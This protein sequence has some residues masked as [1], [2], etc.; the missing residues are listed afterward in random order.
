MR[1][2]NDRANPA[3]CPACHGQRPH[4]KLAKLND[5]TDKV[6]CQTCHIPKFAR[7]GIPTKMSWDWS[8]AGKRG[9]DGKPLLRKNDEGHVVYIGTKGDFRMG[10]NV[11]PD[12]VWFNGKVE[13][14]LV[15]DKIEKSSEP[16]HINRFRG[17]AGD[18]GSLIWPVK[19][20]RGRQAYDPDNKSLVIAHLAGDD[21]TAYWKNLDWPRAVRAGMSTAGLPFSGKV[22]FI[23]TVSVWPIT[24]MVA[25]AKNA[26]GCGECHAPD[27]RLEKISGI[28]IPGRATDHAQWLDRTGWTL[29]A[30]ALLGVLVH[31]A[32]RVVAARRRH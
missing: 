10:E 12:Y 21:D 27:G 22:E 5:H 26:L 15:G 2:K 13:Y 23:D 6:A 1:G 30:L 8:T 9:S 4:T 25:P 20:F 24:H 11:V 14:T 7:G 16:V 17:S 29:A 31:G 18:G 28:Y 3:T 19:V 32:V